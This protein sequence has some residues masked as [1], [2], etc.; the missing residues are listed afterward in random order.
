MSRE[1]V[2]LLLGFLGVCMFAGTLPFT[3]LAVDGLSPI[4]VTAGRAA[5]A[6]L[7]AAATLL[8][9]RRKRPKRHQMGMLV[10]TA[11]CLVIGFPGLTSLA[12]QTVPASHGGVVLGILPLTTSIASALLAG[13]RPSPAFW[14]AAVAGAALVVIFTLVEGG[15]ALGR[16]DLYLLAAVFVTA[17]GYVLSTKLVRSGFAGWEVIS[18]VLVVA[19]PLSLPVALWLLP[20]A[21]ASVPLWSWIGFAYVSVISQYLGFFAWN[22]GLAIGGIAH[23]SQV[24]L[25]QTFLT[26]LLASLLNGESIGLAAWLVAAAVLG[27]VLLARH[28]TVRRLR[29]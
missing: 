10:L 12:M 20:V 4:F 28:A 1:T 3:H 24:Q 27:L 18:W 19:L 11:A 6:G 26:L 5:V 17:L 7:L 22:A 25:L 9:L 2:G 29:S 14:L 15:G 16:G 8:F 21:P 23:V 13:E